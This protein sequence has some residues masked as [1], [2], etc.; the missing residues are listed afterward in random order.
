MIPPAVVCPN[1]GGKFSPQLR[2]YF[3]SHLA[4]FL[5]I[6]YRKTTLRRYVSRKEIPAPFLMMDLLEDVDM[7]VRAIASQ[8]FDLTTVVWNQDSAGCTISSLSK[9]N[10]T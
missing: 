3:A 1:T 4:P 2:P 9:V 10:T 6:A 8:I 7:R 5:H